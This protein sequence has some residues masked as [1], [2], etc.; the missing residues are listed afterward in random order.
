MLDHPVGGRL[1]QA[2]GILVDDRVLVVVGLCVVDE[3]LGVALDLGEGVVGAAGQLVLDGV[4]GDGQLGEV[5]VVGQLVLVG[6]SEE[7]DGNGASAAGRQAVSVC[8]VL[9]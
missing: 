6:Q 5:V 7:V 4:E 2:L 8:I 9:G 1:A 3:A